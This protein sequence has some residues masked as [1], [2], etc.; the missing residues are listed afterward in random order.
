VEIRKVLA[1][2]G[3]HIWANIPVLEAWVDHQEL[4]DSPSETLPGFNDRQMAW[5]PSMIEHRDDLGYRG[6]FFERPRTDTNQ[7]HILEHI[8]LELQSLAG[9]KVGYGKA[10]E[11]SEEGVDKVVV[12]Y[13]EEAVGRT[14]LDTALRLLCSPFLGRAARFVRIVSPSNSQRVVIPGERRSE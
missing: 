6:G 4:K 11:T 10:R 12:R 9:A 8:A 5:L 7:G 14:A 1:L 3:S 13:E 2:R